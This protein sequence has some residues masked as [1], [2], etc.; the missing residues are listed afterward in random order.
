MQIE[1]FQPTDENYAALVRLRQLLEPGIQPTV[2]LLREEDHD[3]DTENQVVRAVGK[4][5]DE[6]VASGLYW[7]SSHSAD[8]S[9]HFG[10]SVHPAYQAGRIPAQMHD[11]LVGRIEQDQPVAIVSQTKEDDRYRTQLLEAANFELKMR[12]PRSQL[13]VTLVGA[14]A[15]D[16]LL[17]QLAQQGI[18]FTTLTSVMAN[19]PAWQRNIWQLFTI[20]EQDIPTPEPVEIT[21]FEKYAE[22]YSG[23]WFRPDSWAIAIDQTQTEA[24]RYVGMSVVNIMPTR[25][26]SLF[27][28]ITGVAPTHRRR[29]IATMLKVYTV[30]YAQQHGYRYIRTDNEENNPMFDLNLQLGFEPLPA[31]VYYKKELG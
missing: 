8:K 28:G 31:W 25:P 20:I 13:D 26:G 3:L 22:Y 5:A 27:A 9:H 24:Q 15:Y 1:A 12:F 19:D 18:Q 2:A 23:E 6:I 7:Q 16:H 17:P 11:Y 29:K 30:K 10:F 4:V 21:P 14:A